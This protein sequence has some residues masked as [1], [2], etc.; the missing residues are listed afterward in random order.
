VAAVE[1]QE[2]KVQIYLVIATARNE[3]TLRG[4]VFIYKLSGD[5][6]LT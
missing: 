4:S 3:K 1:K 2:G 6:A 5:D